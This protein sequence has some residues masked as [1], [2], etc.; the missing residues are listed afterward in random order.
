[1]PCDASGRPACIILS[2]LLVRDVKAGSP[3]RSL[4]GP[5]RGQLRQL[6]LTGATKRGP[7]GCCKASSRNGVISGVGGVVFLPQILILS[8]SSCCW[9]TWATW[10]RRVQMDEAWAGRMA[11]SKRSSRLRRALP[12]RS[13]NHGDAGDRKT[14]ADRLTTILVAP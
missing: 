11:W 7:R 4:D 13:G 14:D 2:A 8:V 1:M 12:V 10:R 3:G 9:K 5:D 6:G